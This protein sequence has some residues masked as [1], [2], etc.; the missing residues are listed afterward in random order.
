[1]RQSTDS[2]LNFSPHQAARPKQLK[3]AFS[4]LDQ[5]ACGKAA[6]GSFGC[7][8]VALNAYLQDVWVQT[9]RH[10]R[11]RADSFSI[12]VHAHLSVLTS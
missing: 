7:S 4:A 3:D 6:F 2:E 11:Y 5:G 8:K 10:V 9:G 1:V 12:A